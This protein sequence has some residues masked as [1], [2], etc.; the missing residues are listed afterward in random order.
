MNRSP[1]RTR[2][3]SPSASQVARSAD[4]M[5]LGGQVVEQI[6]ASE[7]GVVALV[8]RLPRVAVGDKVFMLTTRVVGPD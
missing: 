1:W 4:F 6:V 3:P 7:E 5:S 2:R 8:R